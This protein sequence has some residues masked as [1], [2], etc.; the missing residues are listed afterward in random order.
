MSKHL[1]AEPVGL[2]GPSPSAQRSMVPP[3]SKRWSAD[4]D[5]L[6]GS[7]TFGRKL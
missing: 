2:R 7:R 6:G 3:A 5:D 1:L 4:A